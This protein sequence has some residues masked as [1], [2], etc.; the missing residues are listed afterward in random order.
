MPSDHAI[1]L[2]AIHAV[3]TKVQYGESAIEESDH[4]QI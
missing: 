1:L 4:E 3:F 2:T